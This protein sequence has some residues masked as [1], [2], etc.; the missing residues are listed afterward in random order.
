[1][2]AREVDERAPRV[3]A[4]LHT[5]LLNTT[6]KLRTPKH[7]S[8][9]TAHNVQHNAPNQENAAHKNGRMCD[10]RADKPTSSAE[11]TLRATDGDTH[12]RVNTTSGMFTR[13]SRHCARI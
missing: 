8:H 12:N 7:E 5:L 1:M 3:R 9:Y 2:C 10:R 13:D 6:R 4:R 11:K